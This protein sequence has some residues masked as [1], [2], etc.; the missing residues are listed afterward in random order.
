MCSVLTIGLLMH[1]LGVQ[2]N[3]H[4]I[5]QDTNYAEIMTQAKK[6]SRTDPPSE[7]AEE[8]SSENEALDDPIAA[9]QAEQ[10]EVED[11]L[12]SLQTTAWSSDSYQQ[13]TGHGEGSEVPDSG[14]HLSHRNAGDEWP[15][16][17]SGENSESSAG[18]TGR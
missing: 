7:R 1:H 16:P 15:L 17:H 11:I 8:P 6:R 14:D 5:K 3:E 4:L 9:D 12:H 10:Q 13:T 18:F 2:M